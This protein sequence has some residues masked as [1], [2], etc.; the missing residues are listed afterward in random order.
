MESYVKRI[1]FAVTLSLVSLAFAHNGVDH[2]RGVIKR[3]EKNTVWFTPEKGE[4]AT[5]EVDEK[6]EIERGRD[7]V[8]LRDLR[9]GDK[10]RV[11]SVKEGAKQRALKIKLSDSEDAGTPGHKP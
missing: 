3:V 8:L 7:R 2:S 11:D 10:A 4:P 6:T 9:P 1:V 5:Y